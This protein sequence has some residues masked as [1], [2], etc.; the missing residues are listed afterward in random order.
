MTARAFAIVASLVLNVAFVCA[1]F[2]RDTWTQTE[3]VAPAVR[4]SGAQRSEPVA[5]A[6]KTDPAENER[7]QALSS[8]S[9]ADVV[10]QLQSAGFPP[11]LQRAI[12]KALVAR[13]FAGRHREIA[14]LIRARPWWR[15]LWGSDDGAKLIA[16]RQR[17][18]REEDDVVNALLGPNTE[19]P[20]WATASRRYRYGDLPPATLAELDRINA[21]Y[22]ELANEIKQRSQ[23]L[24]LPEDREKLLFLARQAHTDVAQLLTPQQLFEYDMRSSQEGWW[25]R[26]IT[27][28]MDVSEEEF[29]A[30]FK[31]RSAFSSRFSDGQYELMSAEDRAAFAKLEPE[32][33][34][35]IRAVLTPERFAEYELKTSPEYRQTEG[36]VRRLALPAEATATIVNVQRELTKRAEAIRADATLPPTARTSQLGALA[37]EAVARL[38]PTLG[39]AGMKAYRQGGAGNWMNRLQQPAPAGSPKG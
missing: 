9:L 8:G 11:R 10:E 16:A 19:P 13:Q 22:V 12:M 36:L 31:V 17:L 15:P 4:G 37:D 14:D 32:M 6:A 29:R 5:A 34:A 18:R 27:S 30:L 35:Q 28:N 24:F 1:F 26:D 2:Q 23:G 25:L 39:D 21:D 3:S 20:E 33:N 7:W 38:T